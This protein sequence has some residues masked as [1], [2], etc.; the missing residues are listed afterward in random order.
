[1]TRLGV[2]PESSGCLEGRSRIQIPISM[3][4]EQD[5]PRGYVW[6]PSGAWTMIPT[7]WP[8]LVT[9]VCAP[10][11]SPYNQLYSSQKSA[12]DISHSSW[13]SCSC[14]NIEARRGDSLAFTG[15]TH[16]STW[17]AS[18]AMT[19]G[20]SCSL[21]RTN[22]ISRPGMLR[23]CCASGRRGGE[24]CVVLRVCGRVRVVFTFSYRSC[25]SNL[26]KRLTVSRDSKTPFTNW[27]CE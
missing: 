21:I 5:L 26:C 2:R 14:S 15:T 23:G 22:A 6:L 9:V 20:A 7:S 13:G 18:S 16:R 12:A 19:Y 24:K 4:S 1:M 25:T 11:P 17:Q 27:N 3:L 8:P 10:F